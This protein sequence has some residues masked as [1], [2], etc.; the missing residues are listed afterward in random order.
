MSYDKPAPIEVT[1]DYD[2]QSGYA[3]YAVFPDGEFKKIATAM[4]LDIARYV[5]RMISQWAG[6]IMNDNI[7]QYEENLREGLLA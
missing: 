4:D 6:I 5:G 1:L 7:S 2:V 3:I